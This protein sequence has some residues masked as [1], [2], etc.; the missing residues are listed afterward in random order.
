MRGKRQWREAGV[1][2][3][4]SGDDP[5]LAGGLARTSV[6]GYCRDCLW[7]QMRGKGKSGSMQETDERRNSIL[8]SSMPER[9]L[10]EQQ[11]FAQGQNPNS[12]P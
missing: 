4:D 6:N 8:F 1:F 2:S 9:I 3:Q 5:R 11:R 7:R 10:I 12:S